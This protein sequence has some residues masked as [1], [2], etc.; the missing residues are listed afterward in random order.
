MIKIVC[1]SDV[2][3][4]I[5]KVKLPDADV[6]IVAGDLTSR[7]SRNECLKFNSD[8]ECIRHKFNDIVVI[9]GNHD[10]YFQEE[11]AKARELLTN[12]KYLDDQSAIVKGM[13]VY[14]SPI[15]PT[16]F[17][18]AFNVD[19][20]EPIRKV[21]TKID[22]GAGILITHGPAYGILDATVLGEHVGCEELAIRIKQLTKLKVHIS[23]HIHHDYGFK[24]QDGVLYV[25]ASTCNERYEPTNPPIVVEL[26]DKTHEVL[27][28]YKYVE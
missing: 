26:D 18:W 19:R 24:D 10:W 23:G 27:D 9:A 22:N 6:L 20:G 3:N 5:S 25:N 4:Q 2:H 12:A 28:V 8:L 11:P 16:F 15:S 21:W 1:I 17:R 7:G 14:G 13:H